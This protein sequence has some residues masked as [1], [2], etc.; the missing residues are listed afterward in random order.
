MAQENY[1]HMH[2]QDVTFNKYHNT[3]ANFQWCAV[4]RIRRKI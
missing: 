1:N 2:E 3:A 4:L